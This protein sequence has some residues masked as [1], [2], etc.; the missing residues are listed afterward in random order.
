M[1]VDEALWAFVDAFERAGVPYAVTGDLALH[2][3]GY[4]HARPRLELAVG[5]DARGIAEVL[6]FTEVR[7]TGRVSLYARDSL[8]VAIIRAAIHNP[9]P[10]FVDGRIVS[11][12]D[13]AHRL[14]LDEDDIALLDEATV[15]LTAAD[16][17]PWLDFMSRIAPA[18]RGNTNADEPFE[19]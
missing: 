8:T 14:P 15:T 17:G 13:P 10:A 5:T 16:A 9:L 6:G 18:P 11:V 7:S 12:L 19:L 2:L 4:P 1:Q 3:F